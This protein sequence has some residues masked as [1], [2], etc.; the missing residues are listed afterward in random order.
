MLTLGPIGF[1]A[2]FVLAGLLALPLIWLLLRNFPP[3]ARMQNF[4][5]VSLM[6]GLKDE[7][8][9]ASNIPLWLRL[10]RLL[11]VAA[12]MVGFAEPVLLGDRRP[13]ESSGNPVLL[14]VDGGWAGASEW[15]ERVESIREVLEQI[16][17]D[18]S[19]VAMLVATDLPNGF[20]GFAEA[21]KS[22]RQLP[23]ILPNPWMADGNEIGEWIEDNIQGSFDTWWFSDGLEYDGR[24]QLAATL[25]ERGALTVVQPS[26][27]VVALSIPESEAGLVSVKVNAPVMSGP[28]QMTVSAIGT[29][30]DGRKAV[31]AEAAVQLN[32]S[33]GAAFAE[34]RLPLE[35]R[36]RITGFETTELK[37][38]GSVVLVADSLLR[39]KVG[40]V[41][42]R[43]QEEGGLL[44]SSMHYV[45]Q[46]VESFS[47]LS[48]GEVED[49]LSRDPDVVI[50]VDA[51]PMPTTSVAQLAEW[52]REGGLLI[53]FAGPRLAEGQL[54]DDG[55]DDLL[56]VRLRRGT[57]SLGGA[58][59]WEQPRRLSAFSAGSPFSGLEIAEE[60]TVVRQVLAQPGPALQRRVM[61]ELEDG[62]PLVTGIDLEA[63]RAILFHVS[64]NAEWSNLPVS[65]LFPQM[66]ERLVIAAGT[67]G[68]QSD[69]FD[70]AS[71]WAAESLTDAFGNVR[72]AD[73][74]KSVSG[75]VAARGLPS[76]ELPPGV[77]RSGDQALAVNAVQ[78]GSALAGATWPEEVAVVASA[79]SGAVGLK[80]WLLGLAIAAFLAEAWAT[81]LMGGRLT[82]RPAAALTGLFLLPPMTGEAQI[83]DLEA[84]S[85]LSETALAYVR[86]GDQKL[87]RVSRAGLSELS[88][89][90]ENRTTIELAEPVGIDPGD[91]S[92]AML[93]F[94]YWPVST[95]GPELTEDHMRNVRNYLRTGGMIL[96]DT[97]DALIGGF[98]SGASNSERLLEIAGPLDL[99]PLGIPGPDHTLSRS[100]YLL[101]RFPGR[102][103]GD[104]WVE[105]LPSA[106]DG[107]GRA[108]YSAS[109]D[110][111]TPVIIGGNDWAS[112]WA[113][114][115]DGTAMFA[116]GSGESGAS[117]REFAYRFGVNAVMHALTGNY[118]A[119]QLHVEALLDRLDQ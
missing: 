80:G 48:E 107:G 31:L 67:S 26:G 45:R 116:V 12:A 43:G 69:Q 76:A 95:L 60:V 50:L 20:S 89:V 117:Q 22:I 53:R 94:I 16:R 44:L 99:P 77:Y 111:V 65:G 66:L 17:G 57:R 10:L 87:D 3:P 93:P 110:G 32:S 52:V 85:A 7:E 101:D 109:N 35:L 118:K 104:V 46:A 114:H 81:F 100:F 28:I 78:D 113:A 19:P 27:P 63:G 59:S 29:D 24:G 39:R 108:G 34:F 1:A 18:E 36:N 84:V 13:V 102:H 71:Y 106:E 49:I 30:P 72:S 2:P 97:R 58:M 73:G 11:A 4:P 92:I 25:V 14:L 86:T 98:G 15:P 47:E 40:L 38:A 61:A 5:P 23:A 64:A 115:S 56:P 79:D 75:E 68:R 74:S 42:G 70:E 41:T 62:T 6:G 96:F 103:E 33:G 51:S 82:L 112:A 83:A 90:I 9:E 54:S 91:E 55:I 119:D 37:S 88:R 105:L 8:S 21:G